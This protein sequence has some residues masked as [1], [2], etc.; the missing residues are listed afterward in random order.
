MKSQARANRNTSPK[1]SS[2][3]LTIDDD[4]IY[5][6]FEGNKEGVRER[7]GLEIKK[8]LE[9][10]N[11]VDTQY[12]KLQLGDK[13]H[14]VE[15]LLTGDFSVIDSKLIEQLVDPLNIKV[16]KCLGSISEFSDQDIE[17]WTRY[18]QEQQIMSIAGVNNLK[19]NIDQQAKMHLIFSAIESL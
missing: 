7:F 2:K 12:L 9:A 10:I 11:H 16:E 13:S 1:R 5:K 4:L 14:V 6:H 8:S 19:W 17:I 18:A 3:S 15:K